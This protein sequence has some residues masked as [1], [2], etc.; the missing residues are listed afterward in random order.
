M[1]IPHDASGKAFSVKIPLQWLYAATAGALCILL[2]VSGSLIYATHLSRKL[3][4]YG[5]TMAKNREQKQA[6]ESFAHRTQA[7][8]KVISELVKEDNQLR[9]MLGLKSWKL[10]VKLSSDMNNHSADMVLAERKQSYKEMKTWVN[11]V[12]AHFAITPS[13]WPA[14]GPIMS[15]FGS[16]I[17]PWKGFHAGVD[18]SS[19]YGAPVRCA[20]D[21]EVSFA[22]WQKGYGKTV[23]VDHGRGIATLYGHNANY[24][25]NVGQKVHKGQVICYVG[26]SGYSTGPHLHYEVHKNGRPVNPTAYL[27]LNILSASRVM[28]K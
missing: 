20:A 7:V 14:Y 22:G 23:V 21:G 11:D 2:F 4:N 3:I 28:D 10:K 5:N 26:T 12:R 6:I 13:L 16:R 17:F 1:L 19:H 15:Y 9:Q 24:A 25:V 18:I 27:N 8:N